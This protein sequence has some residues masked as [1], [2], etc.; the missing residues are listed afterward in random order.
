MSTMPANPQGHS[1][2]GLSVPGWT[3]MC[4]RHM[5]ALVIICRDGVIETLQQHRHDCA[6][7]A[8]G[9]DDNQ[10]GGWQAH[11]YMW[12]ELERQGRV[13]RL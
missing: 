12:T 5:L 8:L 11:Y 3:V 9:T 10:Y 13:I 2:F 4:T 7:R 1:E 6:S